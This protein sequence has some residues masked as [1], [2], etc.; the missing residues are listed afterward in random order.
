LQ[1]NN[2][3]TRKLRKL[4]VSLAIKAAGSRRAEINL[5]SQPKKVLKNLKRYLKLA[6]EIFL[7]LRKF[8]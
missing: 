2:F 8:S 3:V 5:S 1:E 6:T 4:I 7:N